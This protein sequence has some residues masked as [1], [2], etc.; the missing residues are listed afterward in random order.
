LNVTYESKSKEDAYLHVGNLDNSKIDYAVVAFTDW[1]QTPLLN[2]KY[3]NYID[4]S[5]NEREVY[6][7]SFPTV[8]DEIN[9]QIIAFKNPY[10]TSNE[11]AYGTMRTVLTP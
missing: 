6:K 8:D 7:F 11:M 5:P 1:K 3:V 10:K 9:Y 4:V 2:D